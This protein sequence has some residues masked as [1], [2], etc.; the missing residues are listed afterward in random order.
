MLIDEL[1]KRMFA[2]IKAK[3]AVEKEIIRTA[4]G[5]ITATGEDADD[6]R[7]VAVLKKLL[8]SNEETLKASASAEQS[9]TL[10]Q[11][12]AILKEFI[13]RGLSLEQLVALLA[14]VAE[15]IKAAGNDGQATGVAMKHLKAQS[16]EAEGKDV[17]LAVKTIRG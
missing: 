6:A 11:E 13:P 4:I 3:N 1:K 17:A 2:A 10:E 16:A 5:D 14:P 15:Q 7:V 8:K 12:I 9:A